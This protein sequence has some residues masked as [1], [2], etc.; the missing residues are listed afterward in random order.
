MPLSQHDRARMAGL[1]GVLRNRH[2]SCA[3]TLELVDIMKLINDM[4]AMFRRPGALR[5]GKNELDKSN[6]TTTASW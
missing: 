1:R 4:A 5:K 6:R 2:R 3:C